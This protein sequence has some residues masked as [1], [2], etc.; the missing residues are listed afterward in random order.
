[1]ARK[2]NVGLMAILMLL[3]W[4]VSASIGMVVFST[5]NWITPALWANNAILKGLAIGLQPPAWIFSIPF[6]IVS[7]IAFLL[8]FGRKHQPEKRQWAPKDDFIRTRPKPSPGFDQPESDTFSVWMGQPVTETP[9]QPSS[10]SLD[11]LRSIEWKRF[12]E[13]CAEI[14]TLRGFRTE[15]Q[16][17]GA[18]GGIDIRLYQ[19]GT[20]VPVA[21]I[22]CKAWNSS[23][24]GV[25]PIRELLGVMVHNKIDKGIFIT[26][27]DY[28]Q[29]ATDFA[30]QNP[31]AL[32]S[33]NND[34]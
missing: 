2:R 31:I 19:K 16:R 11:V 23:Q 17:Y 4:W 27:N 1:M 20:P 12:E 29:E 5:F 6:A 3:P 18:D 10:W 28:T 13:L 25:K 22:Q 8:Q 34:D 32:I 30:S 24:V 15:L 7:I 14:Y 33:G 26:T 9:K 21:I